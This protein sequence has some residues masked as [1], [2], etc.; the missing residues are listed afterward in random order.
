MK[1]MADT[2]WLK[3]KPV[4]AAAIVY[5]IS[6]CCTL[7]VSAVVL[8]EKTVVGATEEA[9]GSIIKPSYYTYSPIY[10]GEG[11]YTGLLLLLPL[12]LF[13]L[14]RLDSMQAP[15]RFR[16]CLICFFPI[17]LIVAIIGNS[18]FL[19][20]YKPVFSDSGLTTPFVLSSR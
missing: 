17:W 16:W 8:Y 6:L 15:T 11:N 20:S 2:G 5:G 19:D 9:H 18:Y 4:E 14:S 7:A 3:A 1:R 10:D 12:L 13:I